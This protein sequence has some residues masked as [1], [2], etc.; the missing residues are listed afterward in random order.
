MAIINQ[1]LGGAEAGETGREVTAVVQLPQGD[2]EEEA[3]WVTECGGGPAEKDVTVLRVIA[4]IWP[5]HQPRE[6]EAGL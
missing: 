5:L 2:P 1:H 3:G 4:I 6:G